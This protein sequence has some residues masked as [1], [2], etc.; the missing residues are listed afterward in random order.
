MYSRKRALLGAVVSLGI[1]AGMLVFAIYVTLNFDNILDSVLDRVVEKVGERQD[2]RQ[3]PWQGVYLQ[4]ANFENTPVDIQ[5]KC[6]NIS[7][8]P[9]KKIILTAV[10]R[11]SAPVLRLNIIAP[12]NVFIT[13][14]STSKT[15][16][17]LK[18]F[19]E[20]I[21]CYCYISS[22]KN[23]EI[24][25]MATLQLEDGRQFIR[26]AKILLAFKQEQTFSL[27]YD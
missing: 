1:I 12:D 23:P 8:S 24:I 2:L 22:E 13:G 9:V 10:P 21:V 19:P 16:G 18:G 11:V 6:E 17:A 4:S 25:G 15:T 14:G 26:T 27:R 20:E 7:N 5:I 3:T